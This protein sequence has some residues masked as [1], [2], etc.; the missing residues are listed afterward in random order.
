MV[1]VHLYLPNIQ[2]LHIRGFSEGRLELIHHQVVVNTLLLRL[3]VVG[4][5]VGV[6]QAQV[7]QEVVVA[8][9]AM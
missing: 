7:R 1:A 4:E 9:Q 6:T 8:V 2:L 5:Q 3:V